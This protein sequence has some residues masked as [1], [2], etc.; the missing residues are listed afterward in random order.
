[1]TPYPGNFKTTSNPT[2]ASAFSRFQ[3]ANMSIF[4]EIA[5]ILRHPIA[6]VRNLVRTFKILSHKYETVT[7]IRDSDGFVVEMRRPLDP[8]GISP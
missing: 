4:Y 5:V 3:V 7:V 8:E 6:F 2:L 1:M